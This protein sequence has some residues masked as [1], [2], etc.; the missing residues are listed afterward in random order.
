MRDVRACVFGDSL[1]AGVGDDTRLGWVGRVAARTPPSTGVAL[2]VYPLGVRAEATEDIVVRMPLESAPRFARGDEHRIVVA[3]G[4]ADA[5][6]GVEPQ[7]SAV[8]LDFALASTDV[9]VLV[10]GPPP[11]GAGE[12]RERARALSDAFAEVCAR[13]GI[14]YIPT[15]DRLARRKA[16]RE[17][18]AGDGIH[19]AEAGY[20]LLA[21]A[22]LDGGWYEWL[23]VG[24][25]A[26][27]RP[28]QR[29]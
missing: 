25:P 5:V 19:P 29:G 14:R 13:R 27:N 16:W 17:S 4:V 24:P 26:T 22:V 2:T 1:V 6:R 18:A 23:G 15:F 9:P 7:R 21:G 8:A 12:V 20:T 11:V 28:A 10:V 3:P